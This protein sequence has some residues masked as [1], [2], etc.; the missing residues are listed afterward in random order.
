MLQKKV[1]KIPFKE[2]Q[3]YEQRRDPITGRVLRGSACGAPYNKKHPSEDEMDEYFC[4][5]QYARGQ[6]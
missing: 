6:R 3:P 1:K 5:T 4:P 2:K